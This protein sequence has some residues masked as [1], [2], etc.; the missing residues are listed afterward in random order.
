MNRKWWKLIYLLPICLCT[1]YAGGY[2]AQFIYNYITWT[3]AGNF[4]G[5]GSYPQAP[6][7]HPAACLTGLTI[8]PYNL[9]GIFICLLVFGLLTFLLMRMGYDR[10]GEVYDKDRNLSYSNKGTYLLCR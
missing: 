2:V 10:N 9:C 4:A 8:F 7:L 3:S 6:S 5:N 1:L